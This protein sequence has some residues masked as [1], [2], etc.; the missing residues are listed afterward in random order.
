M[1]LKSIDYLL[2]SNANQ[3]IFASRF[4]NGMVAQLVRAQDS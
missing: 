4:E 3:H 2:E 1:E